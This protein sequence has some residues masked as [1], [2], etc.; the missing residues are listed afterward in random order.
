MQQ[1]DSVTLNGRSEVNPSP[2]E[3][4]SFASRFGC[5]SVF[6]FV[7]AQLPEQLILAVNPA[8]LSCPLLFCLHPYRCAHRTKNNLWSE[9]GLAGHCSWPTVIKAIMSC[10]C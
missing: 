3:K 6:K 5:V 1:G 4:T 10:G 8:V 2:W 9:K 7:P